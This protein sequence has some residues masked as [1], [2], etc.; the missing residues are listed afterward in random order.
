MW[1]T[2]HYSMAWA[3]AF[4]QCSYNFYFFIFSLVLS[5]IISFFTFY[6]SSEILPFHL[7]YWLL[8][9]QYKCENNMVLAIVGS[10]AWTKDGPNIILDIFAQLNRDVL[11]GFL[12]SPIQYCHSYA[13]CSWSKSIIHVT[14]K[15]KSLQVILHVQLIN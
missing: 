4:V 3:K 5:V 9:D 13:K 14:A 11:L 12:T 6:F 1:N 15:S 8:F 7:H 10:M 2:S